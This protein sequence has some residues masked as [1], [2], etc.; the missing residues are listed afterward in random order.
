MGNVLGS[1]GRRALAEPVRRSD[2]CEWRIF[3]A[4]IGPLW[5]FTD[6]GQ[7]W[8]MGTWSVKRGRRSALTGWLVATNGSRLGPADPEELSLSEQ[9][10]GGEVMQPSARV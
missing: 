2:E 10:P 8:S 3:A 6:P 4:R 5:C 7:L 9:R 1:T